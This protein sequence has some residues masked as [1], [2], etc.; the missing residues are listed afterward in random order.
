MSR[1]R[2]V[3][4]KKDNYEL[5]LALEKILEVVPLVESQRNDIKDA[6]ERLKYQED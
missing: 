4:P 1:L 3:P 2:V 5:A 6:A